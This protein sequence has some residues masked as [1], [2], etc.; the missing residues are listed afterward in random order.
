M[1]HYSLP[2]LYV[3]V[4][5]VLVGLNACSTVRQTTTSTTATSTSNTSPAISA[6][7][8]A[9]A[10]T[11]LKEAGLRMSADS[12]RAYTY[13]PP[14]SLNT[15]D[16]P[17]EFQKKRTFAF[18]TA[19]ISF[20]NEF[21][22][23]R[24]NDVRM[25]DDSTF[26]GVLAPE[27]APVNY[28]AWYAFK[29]WSAKAPTKASAKTIRL[30]LTYLEARHRYVPKLSRKPSADWHSWKAIDSA[31]Y[32]V[33]YDSA[34]RETTS[35]TLRLAV[36]AD[37]LWVSGHELF[38]SNDFEA[39]SA[40][41]AKLPFVKKSVL[42]TSSL[43]KPLIRLD[44]AEAAPSAPCVVIVSRQHPPEHTGTLALLPFVETL[45][46]D[47]PLAKEFRQKFRVFIA[48]CMNPDGVDGGHWRHNAH[49]VDLNRDW[50]NFNQP[51]PRSV[52]DALLKMRDSLKTRFVFGVDFH[53]TQHDI[54][55]TVSNPPMNTAADSAEYMRNPAYKQYNTASQE[56]S[57]FVETW[58]ERTQALFPTYQVT[59]SD[60]PRT[61]NGATSGRWF[62]RELL[63]PSLTYEV[64]DETDRELIQQIG[65]GSAKVL[66]EMLLKQ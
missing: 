15:N 37:T 24:L 53:T 23:A 20:S 38:T 65:V 66:M 63:A 3:L 16:K 6:E 56:R 19:G 12:T 13:D 40:N 52:R 1:M 39:W 26:I 7:T 35:A 36:S 21:D 42:G 58:L 29:V 27:N 31:A 30:T 11:I 10:R 41:L 59:I 57:K 62:D 32:K 54:F 51:E 25:V 55:Y 14:G 61:P 44:I 34:G 33:H 8:S 46:G 22:G 49:G 60:S 28:S 47:T 64:G 50:N 4:V 9:R 2:R 5:S 45:A 17:V 48:P 18:P 43:G